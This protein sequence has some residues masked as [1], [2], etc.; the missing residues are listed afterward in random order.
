MRILLTGGAGFIGSH[1][2][3][4]LL[5]E[6]HEV[7]VL[8]DLSS[9]KR[10]QVP[11]GAGLVVADIRSEEAARLIMDEAP[12]A[13]VHHAAQIDVRR[14]VADPRFDSDV[15]VG[16]TL[17]LLEACVR[18][19][20][21]KVV[22]ASTGGAIYGE[23]DVFPAGEGHPSRPTSPYGCAKASVELYLGYYRQVHGLSWIALR[24]ANVYGPHQDPHGEAGVVAIFC[25]RLL[26]G[27]PCTIFGDGTATR[28]YVYVGDVARANL[29]ALKSDH[30]GPINIGT[31][32]ETDVATLHRLLARAA[33]VEAEPILA[34]A[35]PGEQRRSCIDPS[36]ASEVLGWE[37]E[38]ELSRGLSTTLEHFRKERG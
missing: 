22:F 16:G 15:N 33:G 27:D 20:T 31:G 9:G 18:A 32:K 36:L 35:R 8:D 5:T 10:E 13:L 3:R 34:D 1:V 30:Q 37:P 19:G 2:A 29:L 23:Q 11:A 12:E 17:N 14:S 38:M 7:I 4:A 28:D 24:S 6:G 25:N 21:R 26:D